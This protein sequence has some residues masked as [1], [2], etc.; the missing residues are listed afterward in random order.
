MKIKINNTEAY[1]GLKVIGLSSSYSMYRVAWKINSLLH[2]ELELKDNLEVDTLKGKIEIMYYEYRSSGCLFRF[3]KN[4]NQVSSDTT[5]IYLV[6]ELKAF[7][8]IITIQCEENELVDSGIVGQLKD[9]KEISLIVEID[10]SK[11]K[12]LENLIF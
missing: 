2:V 1:E 7:D 11:L 5:F 6:P 9:S 10:K 8:Y 3:L 12:Q 4:R